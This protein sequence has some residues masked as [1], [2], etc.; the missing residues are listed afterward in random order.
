ME[1]NRIQFW[2]RSSITIVNKHHHQTRH[3]KG[4]ITHTIPF[5]CRSAKGLDCVLPFDLHSAVVFVSHMPCRSHAVPLSSHD[6]AVLKATSQGHGTARH[7]AAWYVWISIGRPE[8]ACGRPVRVRLLPATTRSFTKV[9]TR[10]RLAV[11]IFPSTTRT[12]TKDT[13]LSENGRVAVWH[14][15][16]NAARERHDMCELALTIPLTADPHTPTSF[17]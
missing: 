6:H 2:T 7:R 5:P 17:H 15:R 11:R 9:V 16:I 8:T 4:Q 3:C 1:F 12:F 14:V 13:A 10:S